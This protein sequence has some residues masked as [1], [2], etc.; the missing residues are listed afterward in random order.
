[1]S[2]PVAVETRIRERIRAEYDE[3]PGLSLTEPQA[4]RL[5]GLDPDTCATV[6]KELVDEHYLHLTATDMYVRVDIDH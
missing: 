3:S 1:M 6:L 5:W 4:R 2:S